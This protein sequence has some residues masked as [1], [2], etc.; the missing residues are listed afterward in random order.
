MLNVAELSR[1]G[2]LAVLEVDLED[3]DTPNQPRLDQHQVDSTDLQA[4]QA[5]SEAGSVAGLTEAEVVEGVGIGVAFPEEVGDSRTAEASM[6]VVEEEELATKVVVDS[7]PVMEEVEEIVV[8]MEALTVTTLLQML[9]PVQVVVV[10]AA[11]LAAGE[12]MAPDLQIA[13]VL[14]HHLVGMIRAVAVAHMMTGPVDIVAA[15]VAE[16]MSV[17]VHEASVVVEATWSR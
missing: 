13:M 11:F 4:D 14:Q 15:E 7:H 8:G 16:A 9:L 5:V 10:A 1:A 12:D 17:T 3:E 6:E 2:S